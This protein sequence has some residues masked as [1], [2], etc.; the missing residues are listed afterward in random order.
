MNGYPDPRLVVGGPHDGRTYTVLHGS[1][2]SVPI[3]APMSSLGEMLEEG[4][5]AAVANSRVDYRRFHH[6]LGG[7]KFCV[8]VPKEWDDERAGQEVF[9][10]IA[11]WWAQQTK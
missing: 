2:M 7:Q 8:W 4:S 6:G 5:P 3:M 9:G 11:R 10:R 1:E